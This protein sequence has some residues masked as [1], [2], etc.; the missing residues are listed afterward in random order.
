[1]RLVSQGATSKDIGQQLSISFETAQAHRENL[2]RKLKVRTAAE[3]V[4][5]AIHNKIVKLR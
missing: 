3:M 1:L 4:R 5:F 2:K